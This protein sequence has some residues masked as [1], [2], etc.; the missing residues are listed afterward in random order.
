MAADAER[1]LLFGLIAL[2]VGLIDQSQLVAAFQA[3]ARD[4]R[5]PLADHLGERGVL[6]ADA[7]AAVEAMVALHLRSHNGDLE[8]SLASLPVGRSTRER[9]AGLCDADLDASLQHVLRPSPTLTAPPRSRLGHR[10]PTASGSACSARMPAVVWVKCSWR[11]MASST[12]RSPSSRSS[13]ATPTTPPAATDFSSRPRSPAA[14]STLVSCRCTGSASTP[15]AAP[16]TRC[17]SSAATHSRTPSPRSTPTPGLR[18]DPTR[19]SLEL[20]E[21][22]RRFTDVCN[23]MEY[24]HARGVLHRDIKPGNIIVG[25]YG[26]TSGRRLGARQGPRPWRRDRR[27]AAP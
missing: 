11:S 24:A 19:R 1:H 25:K 13:T 17:G 9:L 5:R 18:A 21:L 16:I 27:R 12:A 22:L 10:R 4:K 20:R 2:Q 23:A 14:S 8:K 3:W 7:R 15:T 6:D 26:E